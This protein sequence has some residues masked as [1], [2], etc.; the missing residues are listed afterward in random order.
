M[1]K[2]NCKFANI[3][4]QIK[5]PKERVRHQT[6][7]CPKSELQIRNKELSD[8]ISERAGE[9]QIRKHKLSD[10]ISERASYDTK[11]SY[12]PKANCKFATKNFRIIYPKERGYLMPQKRIAN[13]QTL[14]FG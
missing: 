2:A 14:T 7:L 8:G 4:F 13:S 10:N 1:P 3:N 12:A 9:L 11:L 6:I 5:N